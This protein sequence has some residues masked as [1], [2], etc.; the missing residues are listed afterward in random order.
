MDRTSKGKSTSIVSAHV[1]SEIAAQ[2]NKSQIEEFSLRSLWLNLE[3]YGSQQVNNE[4]V[5]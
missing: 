5:K 4:K 1:R 3:K 2:F